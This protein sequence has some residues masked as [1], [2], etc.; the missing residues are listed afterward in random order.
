MTHCVFSHAQSVI[1]RYEEFVSGYGI[2]SKVYDQT[3]GFKN[4]TFFMSLLGSIIVI[5]II[6][7][8]LFSSSSG[9][10]PKRP[11]RDIGV[12]PASK[13]TGAKI[14]CVNPATGKLMGTVNAL[15]PDEVS[16]CLAAA[17]VAQYEWAQTSFA[18]RKQILQDFID[19]FIKYETQIVESSM[20]DTGKTRFEATF[21]EIL[22]SCEKLRYLINY[23]EDALKT[24][25]RRVPLL[26]GTKSARLEYHPMGVIGII[27]PWNYPIHSII[28]AA[29]AAIFSGN[30]A[31]VKVSEWSTYSKILFEELIREVLSK[32]GHNPDLIQLLPGMGET[33]EALVRSGVDKIL[34]IGS[35][36][37]GKRVMKAASDNLTPVILE[38]GGKDPM[39][40]FDDVDLDWA[41]G[42]V[43]RGCFIN[44]GQNCISSER[45]FVHERVYD[46][47]AKQLADLINS[48]KQGPPESGQVDFGSMTMPAQVDKV[49]H[50]VNT[51]IKEGATVLAGGKRNPAHKVGHFFMPT[52][53]ANVTEKMTIFNEEA[54]GPVASLVKFSSEDELVRMVNGTA[55]G[56]GCSILSSDLA[57]AERIGRRVQTGMLTINDYGASY[58]VQDLPFG[59]CKESGFGRF[60]GPEGLRG[61]SREVS[62]LTDRFPIKTP[63]PRLIRYP[64]DPAAVGIIR[65]A[66][67]MI[68]KTGFFNKVRA[69]ISFTG[70][71]IRNPKLML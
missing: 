2:D 47:F 55:F 51:A 6:R 53:L 17:R 16:K 71:V 30:A 19:I 40:V 61:F 46:K 48:L 8:L 35:P 44:L 49:E 45:V 52:V 14:E 54:F 27:I 1:D 21:G 56:L 59:G 43:Q 33:G 67:F 4:A 60:N 34:F 12:S 39:I 32:R 69:A 23:G 65:Q 10:I 13:G 15:K 62:V 28:S 22:T 26:M 66:I 64:I 68:Y 11:A 7:S 20:R 31:L 41:I 9:R 3:I 70:Q 38:L 18:E 58:L 63:V 50:L 37:T 57:R 25:T 24:Q 36:Q 5:M 29:A 42:I